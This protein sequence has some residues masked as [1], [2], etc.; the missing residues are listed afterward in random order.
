MTRF[1]SPEKR[2]AKAEAARQRKAARAK[3][4]PKHP[5]VHR[6]G[7]GKTKNLF[8]APKNDPRRR[9]RGHSACGLTV[10]DGYHFA[11]L[12]IAIPDDA[13]AW[14]PR[15][16][17]CERCVWTQPRA[18]NA[19]GLYQATPVMICAVEVFCL[20]LALLGAAA[21]EDGHSSCYFEICHEM[22]GGR[23]QVI[24]SRH[25]CWCGR[26]SW[27]D[28]A[29]Q[30][31][32]AVDARDAIIAHLNRKERQITMDAVRSGDWCAQP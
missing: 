26:T 29:S 27:L 9:T 25:V 32:M 22:A 23:R 24:D 8:G 5:R 15:E 1:L 28:W 11:G 7:F 13:F 14:L 18:L 30:Q 21:R 4:R 6:Y 2:A 31:I 16:A 20:E 19:N 17:Q 10:G 12:P 3:V